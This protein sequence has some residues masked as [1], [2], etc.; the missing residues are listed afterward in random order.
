MTAASDQLRGRFHCSNE[1]G[2]EFE[3]GWIMGSSRVAI[4]VSG[5]AALQHFM[6]VDDPLF[7]RTRTSRTSRV[8]Y[9][10]AGSWDFGKQSF[11]RIGYE[12]FSLLQ[13]DYGSAVPGVV[14]WDDPAGPG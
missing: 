1:Q 6:I 9:L 13:Q 3:P 14:V 12:N 7:H 4:V 10:V 8:E 11:Q 2:G 5:K